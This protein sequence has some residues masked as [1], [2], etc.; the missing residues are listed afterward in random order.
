MR[1]LLGDDEETAIL[2]EAM[3]LID[4]CEGFTSEGDSSSDSAGLR[5]HDQVDEL[6]LLSC[7]RG[8]QGRKRENVFK[9]VTKKKRIRRAETS[10]TA[11]QRRKKA[12]VI[13]LRTEVT[14]L[15]TRIS[16]L[17]QKCQDMWEKCLSRNKETDME[18][19]QAVVINWCEEAVRQYRYRR[20]AEDCNR[21]LK[22]IFESQS[23]L[24]HDLRAVLYQRGALNGMDV[25]FDGVAKH[26]LAEMTCEASLS[27]Q[28]TFLE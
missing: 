5:S 14:E 9:P 15:E 23:R 3:A 24:S 17:Q 25:V 12:E 6:K 18:S 1:A 27:T 19:G 22:E 2:E 13:A 4:S 20:A 7:S 26:Q 11:F 10:S 28:F 16:Y 8:K 21:K